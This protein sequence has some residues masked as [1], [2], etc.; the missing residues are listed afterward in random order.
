MG[1]E[2][3]DHLLREFAAGRGEHDQVAGLVGELL[4]GFD[5]I[6][7]RLDFEQHAGAAAVGAIVDGFVFIF[8]PVADVVQIDL[9]Q[10]VLD[11]QLQ[12][13]LA[14]V[15]GEDFREEGEDVE[16]HGGQ[17]Q[18]AKSR[19]QNVGKVHST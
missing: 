8:G 18:K 12:Q 3:F 14:Q 11:G 2:F 1:G 9:H 4:H 15:A 10:A 13:A 19:R 5:A 7:H 6:D 16:T 17:R